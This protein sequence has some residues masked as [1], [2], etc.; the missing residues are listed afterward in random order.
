MEYGVIVFRLNTH[1]SSSPSCLAAREYFFDVQARVG[2]P[3]FVGII[4]QGLQDDLVFLDGIGPGIGAEQGAFLFLF[5]A[6]PRQRRAA[7]VRPISVG[8][9]FGVFEYALR[10][11]FA[12][13]GRVQALRL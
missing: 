12:T 5:G 6:E 3:L 1:H 11:R 8:L 4:Q 9:L 2:E 13:A 10:D 7:M